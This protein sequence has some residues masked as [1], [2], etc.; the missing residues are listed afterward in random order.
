MPSESPNTCPG[1]TPETAPCQ[2][3]CTTVSNDYAGELQEQVAQI[4]T[5]SNGVNYHTVFS[6]SPARGWKRTTQKYSNA[7]TQ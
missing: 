7:S 5:R 4:Y 2:F 3:C 1:C 6:E